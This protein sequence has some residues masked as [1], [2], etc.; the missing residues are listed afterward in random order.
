MTFSNHSCYVD[1]YLAKADSR[2]EDFEIGL[3]V[4]LLDQHYF[5]DIVL[6]EEQ[7]AE[8]IV[9]RFRYETRDKITDEQIEFICSCLYHFIKKNLLRFLTGYVYLNGRFLVKGESK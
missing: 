7:K 3:L 1:L 9:E 2:L 5:F 4:Y 6:D 8:E